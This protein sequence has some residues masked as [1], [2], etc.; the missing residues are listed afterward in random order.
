MAAPGRA[1]LTSVKANP[2]RTAQFRAVRSRAHGSMRG[3][4]MAPDSATPMQVIATG[5][6]HALCAGPGA[7]RAVSLYLLG[8]ESVRPGTWLA[9]DR[10]FAVAVLAQPGAAP[11]AG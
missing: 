9:V 5:R 7:R 11:A 1:G 10:G 8:H 4:Q 3:R 2:H 6:N